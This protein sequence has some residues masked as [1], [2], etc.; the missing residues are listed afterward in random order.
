MLIIYLFRHVLLCMYVL[1]YVHMYI[2]V[3]MCT[4]MYSIYFPSISL[5]YLSINTSFPAS[6]INLS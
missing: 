2:C 5:S 4:S 3:C 6:Y 1:L